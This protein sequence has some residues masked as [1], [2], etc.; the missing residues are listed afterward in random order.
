MNKINLKH[1]NKTAYPITITE[2]VIDAV[3]GSLKTTIITLDSPISSFD[4]SVVRLER[5]YGNIW[6][7]VAGIQQFQKIN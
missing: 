5:Q 3:T 1:K 7:S 2:A 6:G 4:R